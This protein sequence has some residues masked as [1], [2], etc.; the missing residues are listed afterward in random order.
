[1][2]LRLGP[3]SLELDAPKVMGVLNVT[4]DSFSDG[5]KFLDH[6][7]AL[8]QAELIVNAG[9]SIIDVGGEST[10]PGAN[11]V[12]EP[13]ELDRVIPVIEAITAISDIAIS[14]DTSKPAVMQAAVEAGA[15]MINDVYALRQQGAVDLMSKLDAAVCIMHMQG[16]PG[17]MQDKP[18]Y[19]AIPGDILEFLS[20]RISACRSAG[21]GADR[22]VVDPGFGFGK[23]HEHNVELLVRLRDFRDLGMP[24]MVGL[25]CIMHMQG[26]P[27]TMQ[28]KPKYKA[29]PGDILEFLSD[30]ISAC[31]S[32]G[33]GA[34]RIVVDPGFGFGKTHEHNVAL[35]AGLRDFQQLG[36][37]LMV[38]L[39]RKRT[40][41]ALTGKAVDERLA[42]GIAAAVLA[43]AH[44]ANIVRT[45]DVAAT[46]DAL[47]ITQAVMQAGQ[48]E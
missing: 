41:G 16:E 19:K 4:P 17:T 1:M 36:M 37:P 6:D 34:D 23:T 3:R 33:I 13:E 5:G 24:L 47:K 18:K 46:V 28:D 12:S 25:S 8:R 22:I 15:V 26:E 32:A 38:G 35:L 10:R 43:V 27:G 2:Q 42:S 20:D 30:R 40:L 48:K 9:A 14:I 39:S 31:R 44:G 11:R 21:I 45:H 7:D 29:I